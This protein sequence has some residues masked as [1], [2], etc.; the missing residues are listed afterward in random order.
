[1]DITSSG[2][3]YS[4]RSLCDEAI[5]EDEKEKTWIRRPVHWLS[6]GKLATD[7]AG[8]N[9][10]KRHTDFGSSLASVRQ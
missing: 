3:V 10:R 4:G 6:N 9:F 1:M 7:G 5:D 2:G 8:P